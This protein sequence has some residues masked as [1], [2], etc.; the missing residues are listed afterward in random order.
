MCAIND[1]LG[2]THSLTSSD[3]YTDLKV[4]LRDFEKWGLTDEQTTRAKT[5]ITTG[6]DCWWAE[7]I[8][9]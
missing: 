6:R 1:P 7:W 9:I 3:Y 4:V 2:Q 8:N 5:M